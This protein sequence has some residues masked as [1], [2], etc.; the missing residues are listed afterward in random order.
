MAA[1]I[2]RLRGCRD[3]AV[4]K[5]AASWASPLVL[6][7]D[8]GETI[9]LAK[10]GVTLVAV[11]PRHVLAED[12]ILDRSIGGTKRRETVPLLHVLRDLEPTQPFDLPLRRSRPHRIRSPDHV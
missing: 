8:G 6:G 10:L 1:E 9:G 11:E 7:L 12:R 3:I 2:A 4:A 5:I